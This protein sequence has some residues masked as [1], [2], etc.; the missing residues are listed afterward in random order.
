MQI[1]LG[2][3]KYSA[4]ASVDL[5]VGLDVGF[6]HAHSGRNVPPNDVIIAGRARDRLEPKPDITPRTIR[7]RKKEAA[8]GFKTEEK[9]KVPDGAE[10]LA[11]EV[12]LARARV[13]RYLQSTFIIRHE[14]YLEVVNQADT[15]TL[16]RGQGRYFRDLQPRVWCAWWL[17]HLLLRLRH[18][19]DSNAGRRSQIVGRA[20]DFGCGCIATKPRLLDQIRGSSWKGAILRDFGRLDQSD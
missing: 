20:F 10:T 17:L 3:E 6:A 13:S 16:A 7:Q 4:L 8:C 18:V 2:R 15:P 14:A 1:L 19:V 9:Q 11:A 5:C 12:S